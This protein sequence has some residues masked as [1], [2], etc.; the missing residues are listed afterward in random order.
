[1][2]EEDLDFDNRQLGPDDLCTGIIGP[3][4]RCRECGRA[5]DGSHLSA[6]S[7]EPQEAAFSEPEE[8]GFD[9]DRELCPDGACTGLIGI[10]GKCKEC[11]T[12]GSA[13]VPS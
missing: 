11:G 13:T 5:A 7:S 3:E 1:M 12:L 6:V 10:D 2:T 9:D 8:A 4:G